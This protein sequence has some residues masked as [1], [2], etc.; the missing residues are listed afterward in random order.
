MR[1]IGIDRRRSLPVLQ[2]ETLRHWVARRGR[3]ERERTRPDVL[4]LDDCFSNFNEPHI[5]KAAVRV[6]EAAGCSVRLA[7]LM[8]RRRLISKGY[9]AEARQLIQEPLV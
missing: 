4:L 8:R 3:R 9:L 2:D 6:L 1:S 5:G 7:G